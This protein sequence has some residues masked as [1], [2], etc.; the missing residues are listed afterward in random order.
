MVFILF[1]IPW[2]TLLM[3]LCV[4]E[5]YVNNMG[6]VGG[7]V[8]S[9]RVPSPLPHGGHADLLSGQVPLE[10]QIP[11]T[12]HGTITSWSIID[13]RLR[14]WL[15]SCGKKGE[16]FYTAQFDKQTSCATEFMRGS[17]LCHTGLTWLGSSYSDWE[18]ICVTTTHAQISGFGSFSA[19]WHHHRDLSNSPQAFLNHETDGEA[20]KQHGLRSPPA[21]PTKYFSLATVS[22]PAV[23][24]Q[25][26]THMHTDHRAA[27]LSRSRSLLH[28]PLRLHGSHY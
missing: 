13:L 16:P 5:Q 23:G 24:I 7:D 12:K 15:P 22:W 17:H 27:R 19:V 25:W 11:L 21:L 28:L 20:D 18:T 2:K 3:L 6:G 26:S 1:H 9:R 10:L 14:F 4:Y 8:V